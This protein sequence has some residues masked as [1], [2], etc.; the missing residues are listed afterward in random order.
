MTIFVIGQFL[1]V[2]AAGVAGI[3]FAVAVVYAWYWV[4]D[5]LC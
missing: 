1:L 3:A 4:E 5:R 2:A